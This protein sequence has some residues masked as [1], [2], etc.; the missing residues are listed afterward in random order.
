MSYKDVEIPPDK[1]PGEFNTTERRSELL[2][3]AIEAGHPDLLG[4]TEMADYYDVVPSTITKD[5]QHL[6]DEIK[7]ELGTD[8]EFITH[9]VFQK[10]I[11]EK[12][13]EENWEAAVAMVREWNE[14]LFQMDAIGTG[15]NTGP[16]PGTTELSDRQERDI[17]ALTSRLGG[18]DGEMPSLDGT[19]GS[20]MI[21]DE[22]PDE[23]VQTVEARPVAES[24]E[25]VHEPPAAGP[26][27]REPDEPK[28]AGD[29]NSGQSEG[30]T[31]FSDTNPELGD[32]LDSATDPEN[33]DS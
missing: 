30:G 10:A 24:G 25:A 2:A 22:A 27:D 4:R 29:T 33:D 7:N 18:G 5:I 19:T 31:S 28:D 21:E 6:R 11:R 14:W 8:A 12:T 32:L 13:R 1:P 23:G 20:A 26:H 16:A 17:D 3:F 15:E 9:T